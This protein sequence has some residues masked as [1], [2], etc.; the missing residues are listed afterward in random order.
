MKIV[1]DAEKRRRTLEERG[2]D[3]DDA[4]ELFAGFHYTDVDDRK[5]YGEVREI[6]VGLVQGNVIVVVWTER[7]DSR[8]IISMR[9][10]DRDERGAYYQQVD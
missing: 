6:S 5:N 1:Y 8:R 10:A 9:K 3:F 7:D 2:L 4:R